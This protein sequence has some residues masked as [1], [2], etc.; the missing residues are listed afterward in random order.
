MIGFSFDRTMQRELREMLRL[1]LL[2]QAKADEL[3][4]RY[5]ARHD[6]T[7]LGRWF[8]LLGAISAA[9]G[10]TIL[11]QEIFVFTYEKLAIFLTVLI[12]GLFAGGAR[13]RARAYEWTGRGLE[14][15]G[16]AAIIGLSFTLGM[17]FDSGSG[18]WPALL[19]IDWLILL[20]LAYARRNPWRLIVAIVIFFSWFGGMTGYTSGWG[21]YW[22]GMNL[23]LRFL[24]VGLLLI[25]I[26]ALHRLAEGGGLAPYRSWF[27]IW[28]AAGLFFSEMSLWLLSLFGNYG[29]IM[30]YR[31]ASA[32]EIVGFNLLWAGANV[33]LLLAG[34]R[35]QLRMARGFAITF[36]IIHA[37]TL[38]FWQ[39]AGY[40][41]PI[42]GTFLAGAVTL[43]LVLK[44]ER[45]R[46]ARMETT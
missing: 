25:G 14:L 7:A 45:A 42:F 11:L 18:N 44:L 24:A 17:I 23:P 33:G 43:W 15:L 4:A 36:G 9:L 39:V 2:D 6:W 12:G 31:V 28:L 27:R 40:L 41:G 19:L 37:Y 16:A 1:G 8:G 5:P 26:A 32:V 29:E 34:T 10:A 22:F 46:R 20:P 35:L 13:L 21:M 30:S 38:Y 3:L